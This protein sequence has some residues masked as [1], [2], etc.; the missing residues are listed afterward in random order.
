ML[1]TRRTLSLFEPV[2]RRNTQLWEVVDFGRSTERVIEDFYRRWP[3]D[4]PM[5]D[6]DVEDLERVFSEAGFDEVHAE[7]DVPPETATPTRSSTASALRELLAS[8]MPGRARS[9][10]RRF[11]SSKRRSSAADGTALADSI[12]PARSHEPAGTGARSRAGE[13]G[14]VGDGGARNG[15]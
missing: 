8:S 11:R 6:F 9:R 15:A 1:A 12:S 7:V 10:R 13:L 14:T 2:N 5:Q 4:H 3:D